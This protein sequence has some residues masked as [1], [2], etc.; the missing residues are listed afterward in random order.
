MKALKQNNEDD[1][2]LQKS[3]FFLFLYGFLLNFLRLQMNFI[4]VMLFLIFIFYVII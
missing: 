2:E 1:C 4:G 3:L